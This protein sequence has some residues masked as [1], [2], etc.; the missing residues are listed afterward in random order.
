MASSELLQ[1]LPDG[2]YC[3]A[4][5]F[6]VDPWGAVPRAVVTHAHADR[7]AAGSRACLA[8]RPGEPLL[9]QRL[10]APAAIQALDYGERL[11]LGGVSV[12]LHPA[13]H[14]LGSAQVRIERGG[15][16]WVVAGDYQLAPD[17]TCAPFE[18]LRCHTFVTEAAFALPVFRWPDPAGELA[19]LHEWWRANR[20]AGKTSVL[21]VHPLG[22]AQRLLASLDGPVSLHEDVERW[23]AVY[24]AAG[25][26]LPS[27][28]PDGTLTLAPPGWKP[29][30][31]RF[32]TAM[33]SG[34]M[35]IR[36]PRRRRSLDRGFVL[37]AHPDWPALLRVLDQT[38]AACVWVASGYRGPL[39]RWLEEHGRDARAVETRWEGEES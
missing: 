10:G 11:V 14:M 5:D 28:H 13:G 1:L 25:V 32:S 37:S 36:G 8:A 19:A 17:P 26:A 2:L 27:S 33:A 39:V 29:G 34:W 4:G 21:Y 24:R 23:C 15:E 12:S 9:R 7:A 31:G 16:V 35:R 20:E 30:A 22:M 6:Y 38:G 3:P 18:P